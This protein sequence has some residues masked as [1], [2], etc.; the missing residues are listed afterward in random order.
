MKVNF[1]IFK[2]NMSWDALIHQLNSDVLLRNL[3]MK[4]Q[5]DSLDVDFSYCEETGEGSITNSH[6]QTIGNFIVSF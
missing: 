3:L 1:T 5:L 2:N 6:N 4:G